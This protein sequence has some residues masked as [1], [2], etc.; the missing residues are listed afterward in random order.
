MLKRE[1]FRRACQNRATAQVLWLH[2]CAKSMTM[3]SRP[4]RSTVLDGQGWR[5]RQQGVEMALRVPGDSAV[6]FRGTRSSFA[7]VSLAWLDPERGNE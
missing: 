1:L 4:I 7:V 6:T 3:S 5:G 2:K